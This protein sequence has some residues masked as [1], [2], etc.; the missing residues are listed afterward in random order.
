MKKDEGILNESFI[1]WCFSSVGVSFM[2]EMFIL[3]VTNSFL[4]VISVEYVL[5]V[6]ER[7]RISIPS[8]VR[9]ALGIK[10][11]VRI[12]VV[13]GKVVLE[14]IKDPLEEL[15]NL[16]TEI[17]VKASQKPGELSKLASEELMKEYG[18]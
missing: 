17:N 16:I 15:S 2:W 12:R 4:E 3:W 18:R 10:R 8:R 11:Y 6:D 14:P 1:L 5:A 9:R 7:G 13:D